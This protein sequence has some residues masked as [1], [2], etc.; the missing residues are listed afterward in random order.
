MLRTL[1]FGL[2]GCAATRIRSRPSLLRA[3]H[4]RV[5]AER[6][7]AFADA[8]P[9]KAL[10]AAAH[11]TNLLILLSQTQLPWPPLRTPMRTRMVTEFHCLSIRF[12]ETFKLKGC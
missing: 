8:V 3:A 10:N 1:G 2:V 9:A 12:I 4:E 6:S 7:A 5:T 11:K